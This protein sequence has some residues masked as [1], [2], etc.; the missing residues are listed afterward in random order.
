MPGMKLYHS[1]KIHLALNCSS[2]QRMMSVFMCLLV[3]KMRIFFR[4]SHVCLW[5]L[6][7]NDGHTVFH[8][9]LDFCC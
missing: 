4:H 5:S 9:N 3:A 1:I 6:E 7:C 8:T 2:C